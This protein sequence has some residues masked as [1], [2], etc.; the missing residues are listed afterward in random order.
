MVRFE[1]DFSLKNYNTFRLDVKTRY[2]FDFTEEEDLP[3]FL[4]SFENWQ[5]MKVLLLG[6]GSNLLFVN[7]FDGLVIHSNVPGIKLVNEDRNHVWLE[8]GAG[9]D[10]DEF[11]SFCVFKGFCGLENLSLIP[12]NV[13]AAP[14]Q[15]IGAYG[16]EIR[17]YIE[18]VKGFDLKTFEMYDIAAN[19][20]G[21]AYRD[22]IFKSKLKN[23]FVITSVVFKLDKFA[24]Y[25]LNY[26]DLKTEVERRGGASLQNVRDAVIAIRQ[27]KLPNPNELGNAGSFFK[28]PVVNIELAEKI[29]SEYS[30]VPVYPVNENESKLAAGWL[31]EQCGWKGYR[32]GD[33]GVHSKQALVLVN[34]EN[35]T[36]KNIYELSEKIKEAVFGKFQVNLESEVNII[37]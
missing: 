20:C 30:E 18:S 3:A 1:E 23:R 24:E 21:F 28:N 16:V 26:G 27:S 11:V 22:S 17:D 36:G 4:S 13:G 29:K 14:V 9:E 15:N 32:E 35:A 7:D 37:S 5:N 2:F 6:G 10:W 19:D 8:V 25:R 12:G 31:I 34:Y 33:V